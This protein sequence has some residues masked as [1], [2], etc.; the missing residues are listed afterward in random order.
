MDVHDGKEGEM[1]LFAVTEE[2][3]EEVEWRRKLEEFV[4]LVGAA[5]KE[6]VKEEREERE[7]QVR[8][9]DAGKG[10]TKESAGGK[11]MD[12]EDELL[13]PFP[14]GVGRLRSW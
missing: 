5:E 11:K 9:D 13:Y 4:L 14:R 8:V 1:D 6:R 10:K 3:L 7:S 12:E 2:E